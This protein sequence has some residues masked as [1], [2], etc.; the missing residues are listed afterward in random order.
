MDAGRSLS[1]FLS[2]HPGPL[3]TLPAGSGEHVHDWRA[4]LLEPSAH[5]YR[6]AQQQL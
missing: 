4:L 1:T 3:G 2:P 5:G 6:C